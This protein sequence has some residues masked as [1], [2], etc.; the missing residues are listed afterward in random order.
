[1]LVWMAHRDVCQEEEEQ[2]G[3][4][5]PTY[6]EAMNQRSWS[7]K[8]VS[9]REGEGFLFR[10]YVWIVGDIWKPRS[11]KGFVKWDVYLG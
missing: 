7:M 9:Y 4:V 5:P 2:K 10:L 8:E 6:Q 11:V 3:V 1:M